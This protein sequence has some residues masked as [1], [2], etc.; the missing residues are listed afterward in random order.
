MISPRH[1]DHTVTVWGSQ[2]VRGSTFG[3]VSRLWSIVPNQEGVRIALQAKRETRQDSGPG[4]RVVGEYVG[5]GSA[6]M[7]VIEGDVIE[8]TAGTE[9]SQNNDCRLLKV[10]SAYKP[11][12]RHTQLV[13]IQWDGALA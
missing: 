8:I 13:L 12:G 2:D 9:A 11:R 4:E 3:D 6:A 5:F 1:F 10:D 7:D